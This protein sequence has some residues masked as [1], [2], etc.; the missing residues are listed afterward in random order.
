M[1]K[2]ISSTKFIKYSMIPYKIFIQPFQSNFKHRHFTE[3][4]KIFREK[5]IE[6]LINERGFTARAAIIKRTY[7]KFQVFAW[8]SSVSRVLECIPHC[9]LS[10]DDA[11]PARTCGA[12]L[13]LPNL[14]NMGR[15]RAC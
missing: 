3:E 10:S 7:I 4:S 15:A 11:R 14:K 13:D 2:K 12:T 1:E 8:L 9:T 6:K 5:M